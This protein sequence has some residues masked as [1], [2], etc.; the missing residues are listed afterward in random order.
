MNEIDLSSNDKIKLAVAGRGIHKTLAIYDLLSHIG[1]RTEYPLLT[2]YLLRV[3]Y[4]LINRS[5]DLE[6]LSHWKASLMTLSNFAET[7]GPGFNELYGKVLSEVR[8]IHE[9][10]RRHLPGLVGTI[11]NPSTTS[12]AAITR[13]MIDQSALQGFLMEGKTYISNPSQKDAH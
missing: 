8:R 7:G 1:R 12:Q 11:W 4:A 13:D 3:S 6:A 5:L 10:T 2:R 9:E